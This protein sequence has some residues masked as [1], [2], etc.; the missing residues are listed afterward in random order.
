ML[1][2]CCHKCHTWSIWG[3]EKQ[4]KLEKKQT[5][6]LKMQTWKT[7]F[8]L[9]FPLIFAPSNQQIVKF[10]AENAIIHYQTVFYPKYGDTCDSKKA[11]TLVNARTR[12]RAR[13][14][15]CRFFH[16]SNSYFSIFTFPRRPFFLHRFPQNE[17][18]FSQKQHVVFTKTTR[19]FP[20]NN[21]SFFI[22]WAVVCSE[23]P[24]DEIEKDRP[25]R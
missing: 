14:G 22:K 16:S 17:P 19:R 8:S 2:F 21:T 25:Q 7:R 10:Y 11:K 3:E 23:W 15:Y 24:L 18:S 20:K 13:R 12:T 4:G 1:I 6:Y 9:S 5:K